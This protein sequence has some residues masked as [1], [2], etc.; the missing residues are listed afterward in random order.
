MKPRESRGTKERKRERKNGRE[1]ERANESAPSDKTHENT[2]AKR[3]KNDFI[4]MFL[5][6]F[7][8]VDFGRFGLRVACDTL[9]IEYT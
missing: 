7:V 3:V 4:N 8:V 1:R 2:L 9:T 5:L 6:P